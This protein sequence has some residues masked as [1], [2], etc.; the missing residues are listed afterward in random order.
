MRDVQQGKMQAKIMN[1]G[2]IFGGYKLISFYGIVWDRKVQ[3]L[4]P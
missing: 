1:I 3:F 2:S 4:H